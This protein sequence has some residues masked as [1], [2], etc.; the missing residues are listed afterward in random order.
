MNIDLG[1]L[2][3]FIEQYMRSE[4]Y[5]NDF[6]RLIWKSKNHMRK[7]LDWDLP[8]TQSMMDLILKELN[9]SLVIDHKYIFWCMIKVEVTHFLKKVQ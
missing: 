3:S 6:A 5:V 1:A 8:M 9:S 2:N 7:V 4:V